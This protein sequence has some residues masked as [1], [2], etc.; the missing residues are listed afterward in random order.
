MAITKKPKPAVPV[1]PAAVDVNAIINK[2]LAVAVV[3]TSEARKDTTTSFTLRVANDLLISLDDHL[4]K[5]Q[6]KVAR[7]FWIQEAIAEKLQR[8]QA[9]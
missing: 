4:R 8:E 3:P 9:E 6:V 2:G 1:L 5:R 7:N